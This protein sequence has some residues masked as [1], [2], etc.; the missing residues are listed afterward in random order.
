MSL[1]NDFIESSMSDCGSGYFIFENL[2]D[3]AIESIKSVTE[4]QRK[5]W[6]SSDQITPHQFLCLL[7][8]FG[9]KYQET[10]PYRGEK[11]TIVVNKLWNYY[12][13]SDAE[14]ELK[15][16]ALCLIPDLCS[17]IRVGIK[18]KDSDKK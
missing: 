1:I 10:R 4:R 8:D 14:I 18:I 3:H 6:E 13:Y 9:I 5:K 15:E 17:E 12:F 16:K 7:Y 2:S 11:L